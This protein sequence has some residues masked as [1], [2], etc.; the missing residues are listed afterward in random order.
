MKTALVDYRNSSQLP[1][2]LSEAEK[3]SEPSQIVY[4]ELSGEPGQLPFSYLD[5]LS[6]LFESERPDLVLFPHTDDGCELASRLSCLHRIDSL[7]NVTQVETCN[8]QL[9]LHKDIYNM[10]LAGTFPAARLPLCATL[11]PAGKSAEEYRPEL[12]R[13]SLPVLPSNT[14]DGQIHLIAK[15]PVI[16]EERL[17]DSDLIFACG[18]GLNKKEEIADL[19]KAAQFFGGQVGCS[20]PVFMDGL[21]GAE[22][23]IGM[24][25]H[26]CSPSCC[27]TIGVSGAT[28]FLAGIQKSRKIIAVNT[29]EKAPIFSC[30]DIGIIGDGREILDE[31]LKRLEDENNEME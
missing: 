5:S 17:S 14:C 8:G 29:D 11:S 31:L 3:I 18:R 26:L 27:L 20:R 7:T 15:E 12:L 23:L 30:C 2:L 25:G 19:K 24:S 16:Q 13:P 6:N 21:L 28:A 10:N 4:F 22:S 9:I 1:L